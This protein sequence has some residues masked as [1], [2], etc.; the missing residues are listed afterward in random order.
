[1]LKKVEIRNFL[2]IEHICFD[3]NSDFIAIVGESGTGKSLIL[4]AIDAVFAQKTDTNI[5]GN[6]SKESS[7]KLFFKLSQ[8]QISL[9]SAFGIL[10]NEIVVERVIKPKK[11]KAFINHEPVATRIL[12]E[13]KDVLLNIISQN[14]RFRF[15]EGEN[16]LLILDRLVDRKIK[17]EFIKSYEIF[18]KIQKEKENIENKIDYINDKHPEILLESIEKADPKKDE[19]ESLLEKLKTAKSKAFVQEKSYEI[20]DKLYENENSVESTLSEV[21]EIFDKMNSMG[22]NTSKINNALKAARDILI[23]IKSEVYSLQKN[24]EENIDDIEGRIFEIEQLQRKFNKPVNEILNEKE[25]LRNMLKEKEELEIQLND[26]KSKLNDIFL[27][28]EKKAEILSNKRKEAAS[29]VK[30]KICE[31]LDDMLLK[32]SVVEFDFLEKKLDKNGKDSVAILFS[33]NPDIK[34]DRIDKIASGGERSRFILAM[35][36]ANSQIKDNAET[37]ILDEIEAGI[38]DKTLEKTANVIKKLS[39]KNQIIL[40]THN[41]YLSD[42]AENVF[43][44]DK[45]FDGNT[46]RSF[47]KQMK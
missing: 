4:K 34:A 26:M 7:I 3:I 42:I 11:T 28:L 27:E 23:E 8:N 41:K 37:M 2:T 40:I 47:I 39:K 44:I 14:Y 32:N 35:E 6:F 24:E 12:P 10:E 21:E 31:F 29:K 19:Y 46:T 15:F 20:I 43:K 30:R 45:E 25:E 18:L 13:I 36:A 17:S 1:M 38:S 22:F 33:A 5:I 9:L 16:L